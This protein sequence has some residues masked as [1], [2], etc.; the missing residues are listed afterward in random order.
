M[1]KSIVIVILTACAVAGFYCTGV[2]NKATA[3]QQVKVLY[4][5]YVDSFIAA[6]DVFAKTAGDQ[7]S[8]QQLQ[9][10]FFQARKAYKKVETFAVCGGNFGE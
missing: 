1:K 10:A 4:T 8:Q 7:A 5:Q 9:A 6:V 3:T 2:D